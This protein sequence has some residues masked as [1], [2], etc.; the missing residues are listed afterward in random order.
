MEKQTEGAQKVY[1][2]FCVDTV[3]EN[4]HL[5]SH[6]IYIWIPWNEFCYSHFTNEKAEVQKEWLM[7]YTANKWCCR[8]VNLDLTSEVN[9]WSLLS[10]SWSPYSPEM[11]NWNTLSSLG[12]TRL[13]SFLQITVLSFIFLDCN[14]TSRF[15]SCGAPVFLTMLANPRGI[16]LKITG[17]CLL[18][19]SSCDPVSSALHFSIFRDC[20][21]F[22]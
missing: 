15:I 14:K 4:S 7:N 2:A 20:V 8:D 21:F 22:K 18:A 17:H 5:L 1:M 9:C 3:C 19:I 16:I 12:K 6:L 13:F 10:P 11:N